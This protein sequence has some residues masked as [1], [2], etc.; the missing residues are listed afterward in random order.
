[1]LPSTRP[2]TS[3]KRWLMALPVKGLLQLDAGATT[4]VRNGSSL[5]A[6]GLLLSSAGASVR[7]EFQERDAVALVDAQGAEFARGLVNYSREHTALIAGRKSSEI[8]QILG[9]NGPD[10]IMSRRGRTHSA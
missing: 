6:A 5:F 8:A 7:G 3:R 1:M 4:A 2:V 9:F 10:E